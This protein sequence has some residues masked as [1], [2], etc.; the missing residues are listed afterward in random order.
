VILP[1]AIDATWALPAPAQLRKAESLRY[2]LPPIFYGFLAALALLALRRGD[3]ALAARVVILTLFSLLFFRTAAG[4]VGWS[5]T[6]F[7]LPLLG[8]A[9]V[10]FV[11]EPLVRAKR[12]IAATLLAIPLFF[13]LEIRENLVAGAKL[14][15]AWPARQRHDGLVPYPMKPG[16]GIYTTEQ[17]AIELASLKSFVDS[18]GPGPI[19]DFSN[20]RALY[21]LLQR[22]PS[23]RCMEVSMLSVPEMLAEAMAQLESNPPVCVIVSGDPVIASFD[24][25]SNTT[26]VPELARWIDAN[27]PQRTQIGR[28]IVG[29]R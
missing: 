24:G 27:Y 21:Y 5:H 23:T 18:L 15:R 7:A 14:I 26:R 4:R 25:V 2:Y 1:K 11:L 19:F 17:N 13:H 10:A 9:I 29:T 3:H 8:I 28:F 12:W 16:R 6:R 22:K 20:E